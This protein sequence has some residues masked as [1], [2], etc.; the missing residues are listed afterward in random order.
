MATFLNLLSYYPIVDSL[1]QHLDTRDK[2]ALRQTSTHIRQVLT[3]SINSWLERFFTNP[4]AFR[5]ELGHSDAL[6]SGS[7]VLQFLKGVVWKDSDLDIF[8]EEGP[9]FSRMSKYLTDV[10]G[11]KMISEQDFGLYKLDGLANC[12]TFS[13]TGNCTVQLIV[14]YD[15]PVKMILEG[16][17]TSC[18]INFI[19]WNK[20]FSIFP[21]TTFL[22]HETVSMVPLDEYYSKLHARY[23]RRGWRLRIAERSWNSRHLPAGVLPLDTDGITKPAKPD[24]VLESSCFYVDSMRETA[25]YESNFERTNG[26]MIRAPSFR[27]PALKYGY[28]YNDTDFPF[29]VARVV[30]ESS[31]L[32]LNKLDTSV[33][34]ELLRNTAQED[35]MRTDGHGNTV[36]W[37]FEKPDGWDYYD[38][39]IEEHMKFMIEERRKERK[40][41]HGS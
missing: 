11:F 22:D 29:W 12:L 9:G 1:C 3:P 15:L 27:S 31:I 25:E 39:L 19:S 33:R 37:V 7:F 24:F 35:F 40:A 30:T 26:F 5:T 6:I 36:G 2:L 14:C 21:R 23:S 28:T 8:V 34:N 10:E 16:F 17:Y 20:A 18:T 41:Q 32:Q 13:K 4:I 38:D